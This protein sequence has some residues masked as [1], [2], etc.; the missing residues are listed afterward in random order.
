MTAETQLYLASQSPRRRRLLEQL[1]VAYAVLP[2]EVAEAPWGA[3][4]AAEYVQRVATDKALA[5]WRHGGRVLDLPVLGA[6]T[7]VVVDGQVQGKPADRE[8]G[9]AMLQRL[10]GRC[11]DVVSAVAVVRGAEHRTVLNRS[12]V[13]FRA[14]SEAEMDA[15]WRSGEPLGKAGAYAI[16]GLGA[17][18][19]ARLE[20]SFSGVMGLPLFETA[21]LLAAAGIDVLAQP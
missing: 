13:W 18:F 3:E 17:V 9:L 21:G 14:L 5:G 10:S 16:Q 15:Y 20:G 11:H 8:H 4:S 6:D 2:V 12:R 1:G 7:E 19:V